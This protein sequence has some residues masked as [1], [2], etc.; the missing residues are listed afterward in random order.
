MKKIEEFWYCVSNQEQLPIYKLEELNST[1]SS[2]MLINFI[3]DYKSNISNVENIYENDNHKII[4]SILL[5][6]PNYINE[7]RKLVGISAKR[8]YLDL[9]YIFNRYTCKNGTNIFNEKKTELKKHSTTFFINALST[10]H[11]KEEISNVIADFFIKKNLLDIL[12]IFL[13]ENNENINK[14]FKYL[15]EPKELQQKEAK[16]RGHG[17]EMIIAQTCVDCK[18][19]IFPT[20]KSTNPME[21]HDPNVDL[22]TMSI[23]EKDISNP[24]IHSFDIII[25]D[26][27]D[28]IRVLIQSLIHS[29]DP[30]QFGV[31]KSNE[32]VIIKQLIDEYNSN[33]PDKPNVYL[34]GSV[35]GVGFIENPNGTI[36]KMLNCFDEFIQINTTFKIGLSLYKIGLFNDLKGIFIDQ[37]FFDAESYEYFY[38]II[39]DAG[40]SIIPFE[41][42]KNYTCIKAGKGILCL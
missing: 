11:F 15:M 6:N 1:Q 2:E 42:L 18:Q 5:S 17:A 13:K 16:Y 27:N 10:N 35:D 4:S 25:K 23:I 32:T 38:H 3:A 31:D 30:G 24:Y 21:S 14:L 20:K 12:A 22:S 9:S 37:E 29:S 28:N 41:N 26:E 7:I 33:N 8:L 40:I 39:T 19:N 36:V 34:W